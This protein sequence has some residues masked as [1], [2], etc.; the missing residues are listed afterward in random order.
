MSESGQVSWPEG[1]PLWTFDWRLADAPDEEGIVISRAAYRGHQVF[2]KA[3][4]PSLRVQY[5]GDACGPYK[6]PLNYDNSH[7]TRHCPG[8][9]VCVYSYSGGGQRALSVDSYHTI[10]AYRLTHRWVFWS[11]GVVMPR[12]F[13]AGLQCRFDHRHHAYWRF[14]FDIDGPPRDL[15]LEYNSYGG[16]EGWGRGWHPFRRETRRVKNAPSR[17]AWATV[18]MDSGR[19]YYLLPGPNDGKAD[20]FSTG[21]LWLLRYH[22]AED[23]HGRQGSAAGDGLDAYVNGEDVYGQDLVVWYCGHLFHRVSG[24]GDEWHA[25]GPDLVPVGPW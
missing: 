5:D 8:R 1:Q 16:D 20:A 25:I 11:N 19:G 2:A 3:S 14:D 18:D 22:A 24:G 10:G 17:R 15:L 6:D 4:L 7:P 23:R 9:R 13:S 12:L 21:D